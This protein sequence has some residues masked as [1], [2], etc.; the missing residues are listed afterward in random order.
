M[1]RFLSVLIIIA[2]IAGA[3][4]YGT[5]MMG[6]QIPYVSQFI[7]NMIPSNGG[8]SGHQMDGMQ[9]HT[10]QQ[11][12]AFNNLA[13]QNKDKLVQATTILN[14]AMELITTDPYSQITQPDK[15]T[16]TAQNN[17]TNTTN[18]P[19]H[20]GVNI[21]I[22]PGGNQQRNAPQNTGNVVYDQTK[23]EQLHEGIFKF[24][25]AIMLLNEINSDFSDQSVMAEANPPTTDTYIMR[26]NLT[27][28]NRAKLVQVNRLLQDAAGMANVNPY[29]P[30][31]GYSYNPQKMQQLHQGIYEFARSALILSR[32]SED[33]NQQMAQIANEAKMARAQMSVSTMNGMTASG[34]AGGM[35]S[36]MVMQH[37]AMTSSDNSWIFNLALIV[38]VFGIVLGVLILLKRL[39]NDFK[40]T[41]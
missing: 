1:S 36:G 15:N 16:L 11:P 39:M 19:T 29:A 5:Q 35:N 30:P 2:L 22:N 23:M 4:I 24:S 31:D 8:H 13:S 32:L 14:Q 17:N 3:V 20:D 27:Q 12:S 34:M 9:G 10:M 37:G 6:V 25:Q 33:L 38:I 18:V 7:S 40:T 28:Q 26:Y 41:Q 21:N